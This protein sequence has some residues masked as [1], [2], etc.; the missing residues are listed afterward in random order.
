MDE[1]IRTEPV[2]IPLPDEMR[3]Y[4][5]LHTE[6]ANLPSGSRFGGHWVNAWRS[7]LPFVQI[8][9]GR[10][11]EIGRCVPFADDS[12]S[13]SMRKLLSDASCFIAADETWLEAAA[14]LGTPT[15]YLADGTKAPSSVAPALK[16]FQPEAL[17]VLKSDTNFRRDLPLR[18]INE[19]LESFVP[20]VTGE[21][22]SESSLCRGRLM[23][24]LKGRI[25]DLGHGGHKVHPDAV[26]VD[27]FKY[28]SSDW[29]G[30]VRDLWFLEDQSFDSVYSSHCLEDLWHPHQALAEWSRILR[31]DGHLSLFLP[32][33]DFYPNVGTPGANPGHKDDY[34][35]EDVEQFLRDLGHME[36]VRSERVESENSFEVVAKK[37]AGRS[38]FFARDS[39]P[40]PEISVL[41]VADPS[42]DPVSDAAAICASVTAAQVALNDC[43]HEVLVLDRTRSDGDARASVQDLAARDAR[44]HVMEDRRPMPCGQRWE[45]LRRVA[46]GRTILVMQPGTLLAPDA[47]KELL[48]QLTEG[49]TAAVPTASDALGNV[50]SVAEAASNCLLLSADQWPIDA[51]LNCPY[52]TNKLWQEV[53]RQNQAVTAAA[54]RVVTSAELGRPSS[55]RGIARSQFDQGLIKDNVDPMAPSECQK[56]LVVMLRTLGDCILATPVIEA[57]KKRNPNAA[58]EVLTERSYAWIF[59]QHAAVDSVLCVDGLPV[60]EMFW[61]EDYV[62]TAALE[63]G[64]HDRLVLLSD[65][66][67]N[68][69]YHHNGMTLADFYATQAGV[70][71]ACGRK[72]QLNL[73]EDAV[74]SWQ[75]KRA[76]SGIN[77][78]YAILHTRAGWAEKSL[79][80]TLAKQLAVEL[81]AA[82]L[83]PV[84]IGGPGEIVEQ[85]GVCNLAGKLSMAE[86]AAAIDEAELLVGPD[87]GPLHIASALNTKSLALYGGSH[88]RVAPP[89]TS[90]SCSVQ[91]DSCCPIPCG[92]TPC[93]E[94]N[95]GAAGLAADAVLPR[96][97][98]VLA[99]AIGDACEYWGSEPALCVASPDGPSLVKSTDQYFGGTP[100]SSLAFAASDQPENVRKAAAPSTNLSVTLDEVTLGR[101][102]RAAQS[103]SDPVGKRNDMPTLLEAIREGVSPAD[104][105]GI[106]VTLASQ[107]QA[108]GS[109]QATLQMLAAGISH[110][111][112]MMRGERGRPRAAFALHASA[113]LHRALLIPLA[114]PANSTI[115]QQLLELYR[116][117]TGKSPDWDHVFH[118]VAVIDIH[119]VANET[120]DLLIGMLRDDLTDAPPHHGQVIRLANMLRQLDD[121]PSS[122]AL[123]D[124]HLSLLP[125]C[126]TSEIAETRFLRGTSLVG[127][128][129]PELA[130]S[131][132][133]IAAATLN[134]DQD[135]ATAQKIVATL[136]R[137]LN[138][139]PASA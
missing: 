116:D 58:I 107:C 131:D 5:V 95:C 124:R 38:F 52:G 10:S 67:E 30:D 118:A 53:A 102:L 56:I 26:G 126:S 92:V 128:E 139:K 15:I 47:I 123:L 104:G 94:R 66:L 75:A 111:G 40:Q 86:S 73:S 49:V 13:E 127:A 130:L 119:S 69:T 133:R 45:L 18:L 2:S 134:D 55:A 80:E 19:A 132:M 110:S 39:R 70:P 78:R 61:S 9:C 41:L 89:R 64:K 4:I 136:E 27:F 43:D 60:E 109:A 76:Q 122:I 44:V 29:I 81:I 63:H 103:V 93:P 84:V 79:P 33:R 138:T 6:Q 35:P 12:D 17:K 114:G 97:Q 72:P 7:R 96:L 106:V 120:R 11:H 99:G 16:A 48:G 23:P 50:W 87:S 34:V 113:L 51:L 117:E 85:D 74:S 101:H 62:V 54:A 57:L 125:T 8:D 112:A 68:V 21:D 77:G 3:P 71:E 98:E 46:T 82:G 135:K 121:A 32:L 42:H 90:G 108:L 28:D 100:T 25:A 36:V 37:K 105:L 115:R 1:A 91:A 31:P 88:L 59:E 129:Q 22:R 65:R 14:E 20:G 83:T 24:Y 137:H